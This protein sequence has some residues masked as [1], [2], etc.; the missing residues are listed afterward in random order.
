MMGKA[1]GYLSMD[2]TTLRPVGSFSA[3]WAGVRLRQGEHWKLGQY[4]GGGNETGVGV[5]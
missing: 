5:V 1:L 2:S 4:P 3:C